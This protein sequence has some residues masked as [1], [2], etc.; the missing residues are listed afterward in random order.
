[1]ASQFD[2]DSDNARRTIQFLWRTGLIERRGNVLA[3][4][5]QVRKT[6]VEKNDEALILALHCRVKFIGELL[7]ELRESKS[8]QELR[9]IAEKYGLKWQT[10][11]QVQRRRGWLQSANLIE[12]KKIN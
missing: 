2:M 1:M 3:V 10:I 9:D 5:S 4:D 12:V 6:L 7:Y 8:L 11:A